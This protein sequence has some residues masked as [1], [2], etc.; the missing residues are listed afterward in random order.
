MLN[1]LISFLIGAGLAVYSFSSFDDKV[2]DVLPFD[3]LT[4]TSSLGGMEPGI[5][6]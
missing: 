5:M 6:I 3:G 2:D 1:R 4:A